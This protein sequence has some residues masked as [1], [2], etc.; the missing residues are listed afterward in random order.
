MTENPTRND[1]E[2][3]RG[4]PQTGVPRRYTVGALLVI[5]TLYAIVFGLL[6]T[7]DADPIVFIGVALYLTAIG[8]G[9]MLL[10]QGEKPR[11][12]SIL[13]GTAVFVFLWIASTVAMM[14]SGSS[15]K[16]EAFP[17]IGT[18]LIVEGAIASYL[19]G[20]LIAGVFLVIDRWRKWQRRRS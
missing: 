14:M 4:R 9:Q 2:A 6:R 17:L 10:F 11:E 13:V 15:N 7:A 8:A 12:A 19:I 1:P 18:A 16:D 3:P 20:G 5:T